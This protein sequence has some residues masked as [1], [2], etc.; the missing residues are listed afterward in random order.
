MK[1]SDKQKR[2]LEKLKN[3]YS[4]NDFFWDKDSGIAKFIKGKLSKP[5]AEVTGK[6]ARS[7]LKD[8]TD[9]LELQ[10]DLTESL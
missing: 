1:L 10:E 5:S 6:I 4:T 8:N 2:T 3:I 9:L 7:F